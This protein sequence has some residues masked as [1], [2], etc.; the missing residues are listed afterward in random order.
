MSKPLSQINKD[1]RKKAV[2]VKDEKRQR[3]K[4]IWELKGIDKVEYDISVLE[5][6]VKA[7]K[8]D[9]DNA[10]K[11]KQFVIDKL[12]DLERQLQLKKEEFKKLEIEE[13]KRLENK[14]VL[15]DVIQQ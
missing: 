12:H 8:Y 10:L 14:E 13:N 4:E 1:V 2:I 15:Q 3:A 6:R 5:S 11:G 9:L 7:V